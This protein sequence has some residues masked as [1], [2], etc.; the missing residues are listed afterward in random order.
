MLLYLHC[1]CIFVLEFACDCYIKAQAY[2]VKAGI[3][4][5]QWNTCLF[6]LSFN[7]LH[8]SCSKIWHNMSIYPI[9]GFESPNF[10]T[11]QQWSMF[12]QYCFLM[13]FGINVDDNSFLYFK[14]WM[15]TSCFVLMACKVW[16]QEPRIGRFS[17]IFL[18]TW[19]LSMYYR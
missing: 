7:F 17:R 8:L 16:L 2:C 15:C 18:V 4:L 10:E 12:G 1:F 11:L 3:Y 14:L 19:S 9:F 13:R 6:F 5:H